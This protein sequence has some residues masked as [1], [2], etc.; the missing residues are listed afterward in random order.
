MSDCQEHPAK[1]RLSFLTKKSD[2]GSDFLVNLYEDE[3]DYKEDQAE[4]EQ[5]RSQ[6]VQTSMSIFNERLYTFESRWCS[7]G[8]TTY[9]GKKIYSSQIFANTR[10][11]EGKFNWNS[12]L[13]SKYS[14]QW[15]LLVVQHMLDRT[16]PELRIKL[17]SEFRMINGQEIHKLHQDLAPFHQVRID[18][19]SYCP[20]TGKLLVAFELSLEVTHV[21]FTDA[22]LCSMNDHCVLWKLDLPIDR[23]SVV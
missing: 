4:L 21:K 9:K 5:Q 3:K 16:Y 10:V 17:G 1:W 2:S 15:S 18:V 11:L 19:L 6:L 14:A 22:H 13:Q 12:Q 8:T 7:L 23:K 20:K